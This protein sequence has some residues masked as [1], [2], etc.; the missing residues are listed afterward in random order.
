MG[1]A[2]RY[3]W[4]FRG[5]PLPGATNRFYWLTGVEPA[6]V[7]AYFVRV[8]NA[9]GRWVESEHAALEIGPYANVRSQ[10]KMEDLFGTNL[11][12]IVLSSPDLSREPQSR[13]AATPGFVPVSAGMPDTQIFDNS[14]AATQA[15]E[16]PPC[17][18]LGGRS[19]WFGLCPDVDGVMMVD[20]MGSSYD[21]VI[22]VYSGTNSLRTLRIEACDDNGAPDGTRSLVLFEVKAGTNYSVAV[23]SANGQL[24]T[25]HLNWLLETTV[26]RLDG[27]FDAP[28]C[29]LT[30]HANGSVGQ[31]LV[32]ESA[33]DFPAAP[34]EVPWQPLF[35][36]TVPASG[37]FKYVINN[38]CDS[39]AR[40]YRVR[41]VP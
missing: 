32:I 35:T 24:G 22:A 10:D 15:G 9:Y 21:T 39:G 2:L 6:N 12:Q 25:T 20:T 18:V 31:Q 27:W 37:Y 28:A 8:T 11:D 29:Q 19:Q 40:F 3:Q 26:P 1:E 36:I 7:G 5:T 16:P 13:Q 38:F 33:S 30:L 14:E 34:A 41:P 23:D 4:Y 17:G